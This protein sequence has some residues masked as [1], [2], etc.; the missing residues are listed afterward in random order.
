[1]MELEPTGLHGN[2]PV[3]QVRSERQRKG[4]TKSTSLTMI[5]KEYFTDG[6]LQIAIVLSLL[7]TDLH[8]YINSNLVQYPEVQDIILGQ[9]AAITQTNFHNYNNRLHSFHGSIKGIE[10]DE[11]L[12]LR[13]LRSLNRLSNYQISF[14]NY[15]RIPA[16]LVEL[17]GGNDNAFQSTSSATSTVQQ[18]VLDQENNDSENGLLEPDNAISSSSINPALPEFEDVILGT[19][20]LQQ[21]PNDNEDLTH[22]DL[23]L[24]DV[25]WRQDIDLGVGKEVFDINLRRELEREREIE[26]QKDRQKHK[27]REL[28]QIKLDEQR[29]RQQQQWMTENFMQDG[30]TGEW[31]PLNGRRA[32]ASQTISSPQ[33]H[34]AIQNVSSPQV[35]PNNLSQNINN[36]HN[37]NQSSQFQ[38][39]IP[40]DNGLSMGNGYHQNSSMLQHARPHPHMQVA[41]QDSSYHMT[42]PE[43]SMA[44]QQQ[45]M[46]H[47]MQHNCN[48][49]QPQVS[50]Q[51]ADYPR[52]ETLEQTWQDLVNL[53]ELPSNETTNITNLQNMTDNM[54]NNNNLAG[55]GNHSNM[56]PMSHGM[57]SPQAN[58]ANRMTPQGQGMMS[59]TGNH[60]ATP[61]P[62]L[63]SPLIQNASMP[64]PVNNTAGNSLEQVPRPSSNFTSS[65]SGDECPTH[66]D[67][68]PRNLIFSN[69]SSQMEG[70]TSLAEVEGILS[71]MI[72]EGL[73]DLNISEMALNDGLGS[74]QMLD[75]ASS[76]SGVSMGSTGSPA[77]DQFSDSAM[78]PFDG[79]EGATGG[80]DYGDSPSYNKGSDKFNYSNGGY[81]F[82]NNENGGDSQSNYSSSSNDTDFNLGHSGTNHIHHNHS[83]PLKP[84]QEPREYK[85]YI[86]TDNKPRQK[87]PH[88][89]DQKRINELKIPLTMDQI[90]ESPVEEF[91]EI[92]TR[93]KLTEPQ[94]QLIR[95]I[96]RR[97][98]NK[99][100]AQNCRKRKLDVILNLED[101]MTMLKDQ[102]DKLLAERHMIDKQ[103]RDM[104][105]KFSILYRE[106]FQSLRD[107]H[108]RPYDPHHFSLQQSSD[109]N[110][111]LVPRNLTADEQQAKINKKRKDEKKED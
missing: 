14:R 86:I 111:F 89:R 88:C 65:P 77:Q 104:K 24:I 23:D 87:G 38:N 81:N 105:E 59:P 71:D 92:L 1:M 110:V 76:E 82:N 28:L 3:T 63:P 13:D 55:Q 37:I 73:D 75:D 95:D 102:K 68:D 108:G 61:Q 40:Y 90:V 103:T 84:G 85:K 41:P 70:N 30:E 45:Q 22:E 107:E 10:N 39:F 31:V 96:R 21:V 79:L 7:R 98:K 5:L 100:A 26:L 101:E 20:F 62:S 83:Y 18:P 60:T 106:I 49:S 57:M 93:H 46:N 34:S 74:M 91:N 51:Q 4:S 72:E 66:L 80:K 35:P 58:M 109:G 44:Y 9:T 64:Q 25:L 67:W 94:L 99:V 11:Q 78:S 48:F 29:R 33:N 43:H 8:N 54:V 36:S 42:S 16:F 69:S 32:P 12:I 27:E 56:M 97:G 53:L 2:G 15:R 52:P 19:E 17:T 6:L 47:T 50:Q